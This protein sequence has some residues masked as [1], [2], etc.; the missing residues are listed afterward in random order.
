MRLVMHICVCRSVELYL[1]WQCISLAYSVE[2]F[3]T[4]V[5]MTH[6]S[7]YTVVHKNMLPCI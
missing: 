5:L 4:V 6:L 3:I 2:C 1:S 7:V